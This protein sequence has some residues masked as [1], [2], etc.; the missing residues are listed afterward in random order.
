MC[1]GMKKKQG[2]KILTFSYDDG[3]TQDI[4]LVDLFNKYGMRATFNLNSGLLGDDGA[5]VREGYR[6]SHNKVRACDIKHIYEGHEIAGHSLTHPTLHMLENNTEIIR[7]V[8]EDRLKLSELAGYEVVG[9]AY[10]MGN[11]PKDSHVPEL[12]KHNTGVKYCRNTV[13]T[14]SFDRQSNLYLFEPTVH[15]HGN[16]QKMHELGEKFISMTNENDQIFYIWG[17]A[18]E[19]DI[20]DSWDAF[21]EF[22]K[23]MSS[24]SDIEYLTNKEALL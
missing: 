20:N 7:Q 8:E 4:R 19:F 21:E 18:Y 23:M 9:F 22:L 13:A 17:H 16:W 24:R 10:P 14:F 3:V 11:V 6:V 2:R 15:H 1:D 5:L 12:L